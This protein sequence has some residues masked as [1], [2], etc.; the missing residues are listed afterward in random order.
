MLLFK[1]TINVVF[2]LLPAVIFLTSVRYSQSSVLLKSFSKLL[3]GANSKELS[4]NIK[5]LLTEA[6]LRRVPI[7]KKHSEKLLQGLYQEEHS[8]KQEWL[9]LKKSLL[10][11]S[12][13]QRRI[14]R[15]EAGSESK[16]SDDTG[17]KRQPKV[18]VNQLT[19]SKR[20]EWQNEIASIE[21]QLE[22]VRNKIQEAKDI[23]ANPD[24]YISVPHNYENVDPE[25]QRE[26]ERQI[27]IT[28]RENSNFRSRLLELRPFWLRD[29]W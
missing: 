26:K 13:N 9:M 22:E 21:R 14:S 4:I 19:S 2:C 1:I 6:R 3:T 28:D 23:S 24:N 18:N 7:A 10:D 16:K 12:F 25:E 11:V 8:L 5:V 29:Y 20:E 27:L 17:T 15:I